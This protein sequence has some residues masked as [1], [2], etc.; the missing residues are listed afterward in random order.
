MHTG[1]TKTQTK[2]QDLKQALKFLTI[3]SDPVA[4]LVID[5]IR[6]EGPCTLNTLVELINLKHYE[7]AKVVEELV[8]AK[9]LFLLKSDDYSSPIFQMNHQRLWRVYSAALKVNRANPAM[10]AQPEKK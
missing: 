10:L 6:E 8:S 9:L 4:S 7:V 3:V 5:A 2:Q 1:S